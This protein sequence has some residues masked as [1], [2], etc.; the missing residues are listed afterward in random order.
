[1][2][3]P[4]PPLHPPSS[5][6]HVYEPASISDPPPPSS[7]PH[8]SPYATDP[9]PPP[10][11]VSP[12]IN[13]FLSPRT[14]VSSSTNPPPPPIPSHVSQD[15]DALD[16]MFTLGTTT[17]L[18]DIDRE[19]FDSAILSTFISEIVVLDRVSTYGSRDIDASGSGGGPS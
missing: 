2:S 19:T 10:P 13:H 11:L 16:T 12:S 8:A 9:P 14:H 4:P 5:P 3:D 15:F 6:P 7:P 1:M 17:H 18:H